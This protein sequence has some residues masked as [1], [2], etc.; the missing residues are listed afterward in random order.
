LMLRKTLSKRLSLQHHGMGDEMAILF[1]EAVVDVPYIE[2]LNISDNNLSD[3]GLGPILDACT[4]MKDLV[5]LDISYNVIGP[6]AAACLATY[7]A[8]PSCPLK[9]LVLRR[10]DVDDGECERFITSPG[11]VLQSLKLGWNMIRLEGA[12]DLCQS[13]SINRTLT[14]LDLS[15]NSLGSMGGIALGDALQENS[16]LKTLSVANNGIDSV[17]CLT[18]CAGVLEN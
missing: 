6:D 15:F 3:R 10:A 11:C 16:V 7:L 5:E 2:A 14:Y 8:R 17:A 12:A 13:L 18:I 9:R 4:H 1:A